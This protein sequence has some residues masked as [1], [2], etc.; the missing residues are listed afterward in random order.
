[1][2][3]QAEA[4]RFMQMAK[5]FVRPPSS[6]SLPVGVDETYDLAAVDDREKFLLDVWRGTL[7]LT[8]LK[9]QNRVRTVAVLV[10]LDID[11]APHTNPDGQRLSGTHMHLFKEG[12]D[13]RWAYPVDPRSFTLLSDP[14]TTFLEFCAFCK[15]ES[16][17]PVQGVI[18]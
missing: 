4:D 12:Y 7:R 13:D 2:L 10:R 18:P 5:R 15:I 9:F 17:P 3:T 8:K 14:S 1:M 6:I 16:P 11:G